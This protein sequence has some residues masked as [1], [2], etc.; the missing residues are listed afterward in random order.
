MSRW[1]GVALIAAL[2]IG[3]APVSPA[4]VAA[5]ATS[6]PMAAAES[7]LRAQQNDDGGFGARAAM[8]GSAPTPRWPSRRWGSIRPVCARGADRCSTT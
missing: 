1:F 6:G 4:P 8:A 7:W 3:F 2:L 5:R